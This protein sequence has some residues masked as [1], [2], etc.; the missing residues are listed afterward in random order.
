M[1]SVEHSSA[2]LDV[3]VFGTACFEGGQRSVLLEF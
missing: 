1:S 2:F 3:S